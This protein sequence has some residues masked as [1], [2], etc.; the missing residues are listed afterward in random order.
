MKKNIKE[1]ISRI[2]SLFTEERLY[3]NLVNETCDDLGDAVEFLQTQGYTITKNDD[4]PCI[5]PNTDISVAFN[6]AKSISGSR[7]IYRVDTTKY[8]CRLKIFNK[9]PNVTQRE[10]MIFTINL[11][12]DS[13]QKQFT[14]Y[15]MLKQEDCCNKSIGGLTKNFYDLEVGGV[16]LLKLRY[17]KIW[18][19]WKVSSGEIVLENSEVDAILNENEKEVTRSIDVAGTSIDVGHNKDLFSENGDQNVCGTATEL[20]RHNLSWLNLGGSTKLK[21]LISKI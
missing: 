5:G 20:L 4:T 14:A 1:E 16:S 6:E 15:Y 18:G 7:H 2:K 17:I 21:T 13:E 8:G 3:G 19:T 11:Y 10:G 12:E 9:Y